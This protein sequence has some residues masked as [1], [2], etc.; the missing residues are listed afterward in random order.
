M[1]WRSLKILC[2]GTREFIQKYP[3]RAEKLLGKLCNFYKPEI[4]YLESEVI[5][6]Y[7]VGFWACPVALLVKNLPGNAGNIRDADSL[8]WEDPLEEGMANHSYSYLK[9]SM[10]RGAWG[11]T[12]H[13]V[14]KSWT[15]WTLKQLGTHA[16]ACTM[17]YYECEM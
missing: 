15:L 6:A 14:A 17:D 1:E 11:A 16:H 4:P 2:L 5:N 8:G 3:E 12:V 13:R 9:N 10:D 7:L